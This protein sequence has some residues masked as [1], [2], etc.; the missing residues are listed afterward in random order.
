M[1]PLTPTAPP[2]EEEIA[3]THPVKEAYTEAVPIEE[4]E[5][6]EFQAVQTVYSPEKPEIMTECQ[7]PIVFKFPA[8]LQ[9]VAAAVSKQIM[10]KTHF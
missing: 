6:K 3:E 10:D 4:V 7:T 1:T 2:M 5:T 8:V 9:P